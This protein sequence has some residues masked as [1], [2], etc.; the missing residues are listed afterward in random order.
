VPTCDGPNCSQAFAEAGTTCGTNGVCNGKGVCG[1]CKPGDHDCNGKTP[2][3]CG[4][5]G[6]WTDDTACDIACTGAGVCATVVSIAQGAVDMCAH[7]SSGTVTC[8]GNAPTTTPSIPVDGL[9]G[10][11]HL[12]AASNAFCAAKG[13]G[14]VWCWGSN[15]AGELGQDIAITS[16]STPLQVPGIASA[17]N[18]FGGYGAAFCTSQAGNT[19]TCWGDTIGVPTATTVPNA[20]HAALGDQFGCIRTAL[21][22]VWCWGRNSEGECGTGTTGGSNVTTPTKITSLSG[23]VSLSAGRQHICAQTNVSPALWCWGGD[24]FGSVGN[25]SPGSNIGTPAS[26]LSGISPAYST[27]GYH[28][29]AVQGADVMCWGQLGATNYAPVKYAN[30]PLPSQITG[31]G[32]SAC[33]VFGPT[34]VRCWKKDEAPSAVVW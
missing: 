28:V 19:M 21:G 17:K 13:D 11:V 27:G 20:T 4:D 10:V 24:A 3:S 23:A 7:L 22:E 33:G 5:D 8:W 9:D 6:Q 12:A 2:R 16:S 31:G 26:V 15:G 30:V 32:Q 34:D 14:T 25:G 1:A 29:C 18:V